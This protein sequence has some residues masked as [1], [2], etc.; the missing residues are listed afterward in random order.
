MT[1]AAPRVAA[2]NTAPHTAGAPYHDPDHARGDLPAAEVRRHVLDEM[3][4]DLDAVYAHRAAKLAR[5]H[6]DEDALFAS[7]ESAL[8]A[9]ATWA[10]YDSALYDLLA[11]F[12]DGHLSYH[13]PRTAAPAAG[14]DSY[15]LG[16]ETVL[17]NGH[18]LV[19]SIEPGSDVAAAGIVPGDEVV[20]VDDAGVA[21]LLAREVRRR[22]WS[23]PESA[24]AEWARSWTHVVYGKG[25]APRVRTISFASLTA[26]DDAKQVRVTPRP[27]PH[28]RPPA[29]AADATGDL[30]VIHVRDL[31]GGAA[32]ID[33]LDRAVATARTA[34]RLIV[35]LRD[36]RGGVDTIGYRLVGGL[37]EGTAAMGSARVLLAPQTRAARAKWRDLPAGS[38]GYSA[39]IAL[40]APGQP[41][42]SGFHGT[43]AVL[44]DA[45]C[46]ST[47][48]VVAAAL[49]ADLHATV[50]GETTA[51]SSGAPIRIELPIGGDLAIPTWNLV[52]ADG[53]PI[54]DDGVVPDVVVVPTAGA[55]ATGH[56]AVFDEATR[57]L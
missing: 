36:V 52:A 13:P 43:V 46:A 26:T 56:D 30:A 40:T 1:R 38:D 28:D 15:R 3:R 6:L 22:A 2:P 25:D 23:R 31:D 5:Y 53:H 7:A 8:L 32:V 54:E 41:A 51:G 34:R 12:H 39:P 27:A 33:E 16:L 50:V 11:A 57:H 45:A 49:R 24:R 35:D 29:I 10:A 17:A 14:Y 48:E 9:A 44:V 21:D 19:S 55:L 42:G 20:Y 47:C 18:L 4:A 37:V